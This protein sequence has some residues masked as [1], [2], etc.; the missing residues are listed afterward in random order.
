MT[1]REVFS[2]LLADLTKLDQSDPVI[3]TWDTD[4]KC[5]VLR[6]V[7]LVIIVPYL[8]KFCF[9]KPRFR[10]G[11]LTQVGLGVLISELNKLLST[12]DLDNLELVPHIEILGTSFYKCYPNPELIGPQRLITLKYVSLTNRLL[13]RLYCKSYSNGTRL[14]WKSYKN[15]NKMKHKLNNKLASISND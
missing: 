9:I 14:I 4:S 7:K 8:N 10:I 13:V 6:Q 15:F 2:K 1:Y 11:V 12:N 5:L 3:V